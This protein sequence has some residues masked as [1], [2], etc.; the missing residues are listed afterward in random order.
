MDQGKA[1]ESLRES[2]A[3][4]LEGLNK[5]AGAIIEV[6]QEISVR[7]FGPEPKPVAERGTESAP[8]AVMGL[9]MIQRAGMRTLRD[10]LQMLDVMLNEICRKI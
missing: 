4:E 9:G 7:L 8:A 2:A 3:V 1:P 10:K 5:H 6:T